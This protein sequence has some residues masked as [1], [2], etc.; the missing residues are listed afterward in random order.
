M[1]L[2]LKVAELY[3]QGNYRAD[4]GIFGQD[5]VTGQI[6]TAWLGSDGDQIDQGCCRF[7]NAASQAIYCRNT[8]DSEARPRQPLSVCLEFCLDYSL[9]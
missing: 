7:V 9:N 4:L 6:H 8:I 1:D 3:R 2:Q 5:G